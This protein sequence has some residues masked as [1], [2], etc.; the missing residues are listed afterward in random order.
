[1]LKSTGWN[2]INKL[3]TQKMLSPWGFLLFS[4]GT[5]WKWF[6]LGYP[7]TKKL[8]STKSKNATWCFFSFSVSP[9]HRNTPCLLMHL[10]FLFP[11]QFS[12]LCHKKTMAQELQKA[13]LT[14]LNGLM[15]Q[16]HTR[17]SHGLF[18]SGQGAQELL[19]ENLS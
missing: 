13:N 8:K 19:V 17:H 6:Q 4:T 2:S 9:A 11:S 5:P 3:S 7:S 18:Y 16:P 1:M 10:D 12:H 15:A 14:S